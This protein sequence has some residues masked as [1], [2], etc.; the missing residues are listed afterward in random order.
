MIINGTRAWINISLPSMRPYAVGTLYPLDSTPSSHPE[1][2][3]EK[4]MQTIK[5]KLSLSKETKG[6]YVY[7]DDNEQAAVSTLYI[8]KAAFNGK[9]PA[10]V[11]L[12]IETTA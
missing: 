11:T 9:P 2:S 10:T 3:G 4:N 7:K 12:S 5:Q 6:T 1:N 8:A